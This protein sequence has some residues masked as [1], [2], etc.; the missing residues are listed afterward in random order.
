MPANPSG[1]ALDGQRFRLIY[2]DDIGGSDCDDYQFI[3]NFL[4][5]VNEFDIEAFITTT[6]FNGGV[7]SFYKAFEAYDGA[8]PVLE[9][10][11][12]NYPTAQ[13]LRSKVHA[14]KKTSPGSQGWGA[15]TNGSKAIISIAMQDDERPVYVITGG[16]LADVAQA[17]HDEPS[18]V[19]K[20]RVY[21][22]GSWNTQHD[23][24][25]RNYIYENF[26]KLWWIEANTTFRG[27]YE[28]GNQT[29]DMGDVTFVDTHIKGH[30]PLGDFYVNN[31][32]VS[33]K[34][35]DMASILYLLRGNASDPTSEHWGG[36]F[37]KL[38]HGDNYW[39]DKSSFNTAIETVNK[40]RVN[41]LTDWKSRLDWF[42]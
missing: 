9:K 21:C 5:Y 35:G 30:G 19:N 23:P 39:G 28:G 12:S 10:H 14:G 24:Y 20:L 22:V 7:Q 34:E 13:E 8:F 16:G 40:W 15:P 25:S 42:V 33:M 1:G 4:F 37:V 18:I 41:Y 17:L 2:T 6:P 38:P 29:G 32:H 31:C 3:A 26:P 36:S 27:I 11:K